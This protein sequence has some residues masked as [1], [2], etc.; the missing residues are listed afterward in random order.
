MQAHDI[1]L[2]KY[3][4]LLYI[5]FQI[6]MMKFLTKIIKHFQMNCFK[7]LNLIYIEILQCYLFIFYILQSKISC[8]NILSVV[9]SNNNIIF[10]FKFN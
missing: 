6:Q 2:E 1:F 8:F 3:T 5:T 7:V 4:H 10:K 9:N